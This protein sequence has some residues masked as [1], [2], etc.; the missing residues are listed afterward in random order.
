MITSK[1]EY[2]YFLNADRISLGQTRKRPHVVSIW[3]ADI[4]WKYERQLR[5]VEFFHN[6]RRNGIWFPIY[7]F[8]QY[9]LF[10]MQVKTGMNIPINVF[11]PGLCITHVGPIIINGFA[12]IG[13]NCTLHPFSVIGISG[14]DEG[15]KVA[16]IHDD[17]YIGMGAMILGE[18]DIADNVVI[19]ANAVVTK[20]IRIPN[21]TWGGVPAIQLSETGN[22]IPHRLRGADIAKE[23]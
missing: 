4:I 2:R 14:R 7:K 1:Q 11:G 6:C 13:K 17:V 5:K 21:T 10:R 3:E 9:R 16:T 20:T 8:E 12:S 23:M 18:I 15:F 19:A 22:P